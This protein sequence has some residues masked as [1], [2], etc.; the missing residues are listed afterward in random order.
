MKEN[1]IMRKRY[2]KGS[3]QELR[4][5]WIAR[6]YEDG[7]RKAKTLG[8]VGK[9]MTKARALR[10]LAA[11]VAPV[12]ERDPLA[13]AGSGFGEFLRGVYFPFYRRKWKRTTMTTNEERIG[14]HLDGAFGARLLGS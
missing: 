11:I 10:E 4:G 6:W 1:I 5:F 14:Y 3:L 2:Q 13:T 7:S 12:N 8:R 9:K